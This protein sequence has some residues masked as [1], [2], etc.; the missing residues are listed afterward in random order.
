MG[1]VNITPDSFSDGGQ[2]L[3]VSAAVDHALQLEAD[4]AHL[5]DLGGEST[6]PGATEVTVEEELRRVIPVVTAL[7]GRVQIPLSID[8][9]KSEV[10]R[11]AL[12]AGAMIINDISGLRHDAA[13]VEVCVEFRAGVIC[14]HMQGTPRTMQ[15]A[16]HYTNVVGEICNFFRTRQTELCQRGLQQNQLVWDP[17]VGFGKSAEHNVTILS[18]IAQFHELG[19]PVLIGH[20]RK[21]FLQKVIGRPVDERQFGT[22]GVS[23]GVI[24][25]GAD[26]IRVHDV[27][28]H[29]DAL[30]AFR[31]VTPSLP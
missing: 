28:A 5:L 21:R 24:A 10:A 23:L 18:S 6:R 8:T 7:A 4:G 2:W 22:L 30:I 17:G 25:Q 15:Q 9:T 11:E 14:M 16:P 29:R 13:M 19:R 26:I 20:S 27:A 12:A 31:A 3:D 1:I